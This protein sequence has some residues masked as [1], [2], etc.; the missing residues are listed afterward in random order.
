MKKLLSLDTEDNSKAKVYILNFYDGEKHYT[1]RK[2]KDALKWLLKQQ[3]FE[4][5]CTN[6][7][8]DLGNLFQDRFHYLEIS[9]IQ[10][11]IINAKIKD[12][13]IE[14]RDTLNHWKMSVEEM[15]N[16]I[17][18]PKFK[19]KSFNNVKYCRR[20]SEITWKF[21]M[22]MKERY[23]KI[24][25]ELKATIG[26][27]ALRF[28]QTKY[29]KHNHKKLFTK[30]T[31]EFM[32]K[33]YYGGRTEI[34]FNKPIE[35]NIWYFDFNSLYP[36][37]MLR[38]MPVLNPYFFTKNPNFKNEGICHVR[39]S[40]SKPL[41]IPYL[42][43]RDNDGRLLFP[44]GVLDGAY[45]YFEI[46]EALKKGYVIEKIHNA[47]E[48]PQGTFY[49]FKA[50][51]NELWGERQQ[52]QS[53]GDSLLS[54]TFKLLLNNL[55]GKFAQGNEYTKLLP[56]TRKPKV[57][58]EILGNMI[59][60]KVKGEYPL[61]TNVIWSAYVTA[62]ARDLLWHAM[63]KIEKS[64]GLLIYCDTDSVI[65]ENDK[66]I[67]ENSKNLGELKLEG[68]FSYAHFKLPKLYRL[69][70]KLKKTEITKAKG[71]PKKF[72]KT[73]FDEGRVE[74]SRPYKIREVLRRNLSPKRKYKLKVNF[75]DTIEK[76]SNK[77]YDK[78]KVLKNG[79]TFPITV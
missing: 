25:C 70:E 32:L 50:F 16:R 57:G 52:A 46:R 79:T 7:G 73:F 44:L 26:S 77:K 67:F 15:G 3:D 21:V 69:I 1:F 28:F 59:L 42:P 17:G 53:Q 37:V 49:P 75:W 9:Y 55:Y 22:S 74:F 51:V 54:D 62:Y 66:P 6:V 68:E 47:I 64:G 78:R 58:D 39:L 12:L 11:R 24:G 35:G 38:P 60:R 14:F 65:F 63:D 30:K 8:Y 36:S 2:P 5:W 45:T 4:I 48:F 20:D 72:A 33:G 13:N 27:T 34:F 61:H 56:L 31:V 18:L 29:F 23:E 71:V 41:N 10:S 43:F 40:T 76:Q 19:T